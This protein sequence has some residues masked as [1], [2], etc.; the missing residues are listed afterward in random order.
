[1]PASEL[2]NQAHP[3][4]ADWLVRIL[5]FSLLI[6]LGIT[7]PMAPGIDLDPS[8]RIALGLFY[9][10]GLQFGTDVVFTYGPL[11][12]LLGKTYSGLF[13][14]SLLAWQVAQSAI[15]AALLM[16]LALRLQGYPRIIFVSYFVL[17]GLYYEDLLQQILLVLVGIELFAPSSR[18]TP[19][20]NA[21]AGLFLALLALIKFTNLM[22][23]AAIV[24]AA[25]GL[26]FWRGERGGA[27]RMLAWHFGG[28]IAG[29]M[30]F[31]QNPLNLP[32]Y[33]LN[34][35]EISQ[36]YQETMGIDT[37]PAALWRGLVVLGLLACY[38][39]VFLATAL[40]RARALALSA[41]IGAFLL[42]NWKHGF[43]RSDGHM[44]GFFY[45]AI[46]VAVSFPV[47]LGDDG[48][49]GRLQRWVLAAAAAIALTGVEVAL[50][51]VVRGVLGSLQERYYT[52]LEAVLDPQRLQS[53]YREM[54]AK[55]Q[56]L[57]H[58]PE[59][60]RVVGDASIDVLGNEQ[61][62]AIFN[63]L[64]Y[65]PRPVL[66]GYSAYRP[67][68]ARLNANHYA[69]ERAPEYALLKLQTIDERLV[70]LD[71]SELLRLF[72]HRYQYVLTEH[73]YQLWRRRPGAWDP[74]PY[75]PQ[76]L[77]SDDV[78]VG[79]AW[80]LEE[81]SGRHLWAE[82]DLRPSLLGRLRAFF[83]KPPMV[84]LRLEDTHG[85][86]SEYRLPPPQAATGF[87]INP[88]V[89]DL[90][91]FLRFAG[92]NPERRIRSLTVLVARGD[93]RYFAG[94]ARCT[95]SAIPAPTS[96][97][98]YFSDAARRRFYM[99]KSVPLAFTSHTEPSDTVV[100]GRPVMVFHAP[101][102]LTFDIPAGAREF[103]GAYGF[104]PGAYTNGGNTDGAGF[105]VTWQI[106]NEEQ[107]LVER[108]LEPVK[109]LNDR[110]FQ[111]FSVPLPD[112]PG[113]QVRLRI[114]P[115]NAGNFAWDWTFWTGLEFR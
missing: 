115:G 64:N 99:F 48:R 53:K 32:A 59:T 112:R 107:I 7:L 21:A 61:A 105:L 39:I 80:N 13:F 65:Q 43:V 93:R 94:S 31:R 19:W 63:G 110:G 23:A 97:R 24:I 79:R 71:D 34:S 55:Q 114:M 60:R 96:G 10:Q 83:Y 88:V 81:F 108:T 46:F 98:E 78:P 38:L 66:Q 89:E 68:L 26:Q 85:N 25:A 106:G 30:F 50:P 17:F 111:E 86:V 90:L 49:F 3:T 102:E 27:A 36:G 37:P 6:L 87:I 91:S 22:L 95:V 92:G 1:M 28:F 75:A 67:R 4:A 15:I 103:T 84:R 8:W 11:G 40:D 18:R 74:A 104:V 42:L 41:A 2:P 45:A 51:G 62:A 5:C 101:S 100:D 72:P 52:N 76:A 47:L 44:I 33:F 109:R 54:L 58:L 20:V 82:I 12:F 73:G 113:G 77:R 35:W 69:S 29:W 70:A 57:C 56:L 9:R 16:R 14:W